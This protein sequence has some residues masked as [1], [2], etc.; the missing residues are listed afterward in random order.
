MSFLR[1]VQA[2]HLEAT[3][4]K[5]QLETIFHPEFIQ[6]ISQVDPYQNSLKAHVETY[7]ALDTD[8]TF[9]F[10]LNVEAETFTEGEVK[11]TGYLTHSQ[12]GVGAGIWDWTKRFEDVDEVIRYDPFE[13]DP[14]SLNE[15]IADFRREKEFHES[16]MGSSCLVPYFL[17][18]T[19]FF[20]LITVFGWEM[21]CYTIKDREKEIKKLIERFANYS[22]QQ[23]EALS[24]L[25]YDM[26]IS[27][28]DIAMA[29]GLAFSKSWYQDQIF[30]WYE[31]IW[32]ALKKHGTRVVFWSDGKIDSVV[33]EIFTLGADG[34]FLEPMNDIEKIA[35]QFGKEKIIIG[36]INST[37]LTFGDKDDI[38]TELKRV[39]SAT[40][41]CPAYIIHA[42]G[43]IP[44]N[45]PLRNVETY[46][47][48]CETYRCEGWI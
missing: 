20:Y 37:I 28:D 24:Q 5:P 38:R 31:K 39:F 32:Q 9:D 4:K 16:L 43:G 27:H 6:N 35:Q 23:A 45:V 12:W 33:E 30:P 1:A 18:S 13:H 17:R 42:A 36:N 22:I 46:F 41:D 21:T 19:L 10:S 7:K 14:R 29:F 25:G 2:I 3:D 8:I 44:H 15:M 48:L 34:I 11:Y 26:I 40:R 47:Q